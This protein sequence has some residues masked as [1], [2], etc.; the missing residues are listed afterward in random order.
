MNLND[1][2]KSLIVDIPVAK[3]E[4]KQAKPKEQKEAKPKAKPKPRAK[5]AAMQESETVNL[6]YNVISS[7]IIIYNE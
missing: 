2:Y 7:R 4:K 1:T 3:K 6:K 5:K